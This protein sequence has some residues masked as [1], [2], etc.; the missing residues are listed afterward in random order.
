MATGPFVPI[1][2]VE[3]TFSYINKASGEITKEGGV[4]FPNAHG[5]TYYNETAV[6]MPDAGPHQRVSFEVRYYWASHQFH[7]STATPEF[8]PSSFYP[9]QR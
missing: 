1:I 6:P 8:F 5:P 3:G 2:S 9:P 4:A 7:P